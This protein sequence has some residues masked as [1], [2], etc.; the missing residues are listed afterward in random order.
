M[1]ARADHDP[2]QRRGLGLA[3]AGFIILETAVVY[4]VV[5]YTVVVMATVYILVMKALPTLEQT[6]VEASLAH[7]LMEEVQQRS[8]NLATNAPLGYPMSAVSISSSAATG[9]AA[10][11]TIPQFNKWTE[12][13][14]Q[15]PAGNALS[16]FAGYSRSVSVSYVNGTTFAASASPT[17]YMLVTVCAAYTKTGSSSCQEWLAT[18]H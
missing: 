16:G 15:D 12:S 14:P 4:I 10:I 2:R 9:K 17:S 13:P 18:Q 6:E 3:R 8:W 5:S 7:E 1:R 11:T